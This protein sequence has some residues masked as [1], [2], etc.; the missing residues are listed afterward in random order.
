[1]IRLPDPCLVVLVGASGAGKTHWARQWF[2]PEQVV[3]SDSL[4]AVVGLGEHDQRASKD[5]FAVLDLIVERRL[6]RKLTT[7]I[8]S[9]AL[10]AERR[11]SYVAAARK[12]GLP[13]FAVVFDT[14]DDVCRA[15]NKDRPQP[16]PAKVLRGQLD[17]ADA[18]RASI[19]DEEFDAVHL[20]GPAVIVRPEYLHAPAFATRQKEAPVPLEFGVQVSRFS[21]DVDIAAV[22]RAAE[23]AGFTSLSVMDHFVQIPVVGREWEDMLESYTTLGYLA[24][25]TS[26]LRLGTL[27]TGVTYRNLAHLAKIVA[28]LDVLSRGRAFCGMGAAWFKREHDLYGWEFPPVGRRYELLEDALQLLPLM[29]GPGS[30]SFKGRTVEVP[31]AICYPRPVQA[32]IPILVGGSGERRTLKLVARYADA[33]NLFGDAPTVRHKVDVLRAHCVAVDRD[34]A[35]ITVTQLSTVG[36]ASVDDQI[37]RYR[38]LADAGVQEA[39][40]GLHTVEAIEQFAPVVSAFR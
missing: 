2:A 21:S 25:V 10:E 22:A 38:E 20:A 27:V 14:S 6:G 17:A 4:R 9:T 13:V 31:E 37:G 11:R 36:A 29:W 16:V 39:I 28:T 33:C 12:A 18:L 7:V 34:P 8:D 23:Q 5:A 40:V 32:R 3:S 24:G 1:M 15:R 26:S 30:P 35:E 19:G